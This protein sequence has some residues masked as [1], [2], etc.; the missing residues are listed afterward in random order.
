MYTKFYSIWN[1]HLLKFIRFL[2]VTL[3]HSLVLSLLWHC[4]WYHG[5]RKTY[6]VQKKCKEPFVHLLA[7]FSRKMD[8]SCGLGSWEI[9]LEESEMS[10]IKA[11]E[12]YKN[13]EAF[14]GPP[15]VFEQFEKC[16]AGHRAQ[17]KKLGNNKREEPALQENWKRIPH[18]THNHRGEPNFDLHPAKPLLQE[19]VD[20]KLHEVLCPSQL[21]LLRVEYMDFTPRK[22]KDLIN[23]MVQ[24]IKYEHYLQWKQAKDKAKKIYHPDK[25]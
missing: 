11:W 22:F 8:P 5:W 4:I 10:A 9:P 19:D 12:I 25:K 13:H 1:S 6:K 16:L 15:V 7:Q 2:F 23:Q 24:H 21:W 17:V 14:A 3:M 20:N 18:K